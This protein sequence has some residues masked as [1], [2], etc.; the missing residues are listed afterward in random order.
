MTSRVRLLSRAEIPGHLLELAAYRRGDERSPWNIYRA[1][2]NHPAMVERWLSFNESLRFEGSLTER[3]RELLILRT[4]VNCNCVYEWGQH[5]PYAR[6]AGIDDAALNALCMPLEDHAWEDREQALL[7]IAD[8][9]HRDCDI[10]DEGWLDLS[11]YFD[12]KQIIEIL[13]IV[14]E[15]Q[16]VAYLLKGLRVEP[17]PLLEAFPC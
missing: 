16:M 3:D 15:Y 7:R 8:Q 11:S 5:M 13:M 10:D 12:I 6:R 17:D 14:G 1:L 9:L 4:S 2:A